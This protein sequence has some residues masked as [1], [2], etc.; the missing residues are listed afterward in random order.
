MLTFS[1]PFCLL[2]PDDDYKIK[3]ADDDIVTVKLRKIIPK[4]FDE[5]LPFRGLLKGELDNISS[6]KLYSPNRGG[7]GWIDKYKLS[8]YN[9]MLIVLEYKTL[10][11][12]VSP[13]QYLQD[14]INKDVNIQAD[15]QDNIELNK[16]NI[17]NSIEDKE[18]G[19][20]D[21]YFTN[22]HTEG[23]KLILN[24]EVK[25]DRYGRCR[26]TRV[27][28]TSNKGLHYEEEFDRAIRAVNLLIYCYRLQTSNYWITKISKKEVFSFKNIHDSNFNYSMTESGYGQYAFDIGKNKVD[29]I[30]EMLMVPTDKPFLPFTVF[31]LKMD[32]LKALEE[33]NYSLALIYMVTALE[34]LIKIVLSYYYDETKMKEVDET[35]SLSKLISEDLVDVFKNDEMKGLRKPVFDAINI[36]NDVIHRAKTDLTREETVRLLDGVEIFMKLLFDR[37]SKL[38]DSS[39]VKG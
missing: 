30:R 35:H 24:C 2:L 32:T 8:E 38:I 4:I 17:R 1:L 21:D 3:L 31:H 23:R 34:S 9:E 20:S 7:L 26:Y 18:Y 11:G 12:K 13:P 10:D 36:R 22:S 37:F 14:I 6:L 39:L 28:Y 15:I 33:E 25:K 16:S 29:E 19:L 27:G 5:R